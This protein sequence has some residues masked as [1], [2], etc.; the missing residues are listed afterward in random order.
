MSSESPPQPPPSHAGRIPSAV[1]I[2]IFRDPGNDLRVVLVV[3]ASGGLHGGQVALPGGKHEPNDNS[4]LDT[5]LRETEEEI[6]LRRKEVD[7]LAALAP[8]DART[9]SF[10]VYPFLARVAPAT[11][12]RTS[13][14]EV[15]DVITP[16]VID[17]ADRASRS[18]RTLSFPGWEEPRR[19]ECVPLAA[20]LPLWGLTLRLLDG[21]VPR[22]MAGE[23]PL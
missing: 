10:R 12:W 6:G 4:V 5:A 8:I 16:R 18:M 9:T 20:G 2:P 17:L 14:A 15:S 19:I 13:A 11:R 7:V 3:R 23:W 21:V 1:L 22:L